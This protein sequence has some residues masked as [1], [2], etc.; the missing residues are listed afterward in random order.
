MRINVLTKSAWKYTLRG[1]L[2][3]LVFIIGFGIF[4]EPCFTCSLRFVGSL[5]WLFTG[6]PDGHMIVSV[7][8]GNE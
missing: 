1:Q 2:L 4:G 6:Q 3:K 8:Y 7:N 5:C